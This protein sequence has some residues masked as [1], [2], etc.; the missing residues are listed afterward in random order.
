MLRP[1]W[2]TEPSAASPAAS[3]RNGAPQTRNSSGLEQFFTS[4]QGRDSLSILDFSGASQANIS[5]I[6]NLGHRIYS[7]D[8][9]A[10]LADAFGSGSDYLEKQNDEEKAGEFLAQTLDFPEGHFDGA[11]VWDTLQFLSPT[12]V[13]SVVERLHR[14]L[15]PS[16]SLLLFFNANEKATTI[17]LYS[18]RINDAKTLSLTTRGARNA[19]QFYNNRMIEKLF[20][21]FASVKF[22]L[23]R[24]NLREI[25]VRR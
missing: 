24:D 15:R 25:I 4:L 17:P 6:T 16:A 8:V 22:F 2:K 23:T 13:Q 18:Y 3:A 10:A 21:N 20:Q 5:F 14:I 12:L 7:E 19:G 11:L 9:M 1:R